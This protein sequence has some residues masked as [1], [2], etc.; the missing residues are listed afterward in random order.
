ME[1]NKASIRITFD[2]FGTKLTYLDIDSTGKVIDCH[3]HHRQ[4]WIGR[5]FN[6]DTVKQGLY[7]EYYLTDS[8]SEPINYRVKKII[9]L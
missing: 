7:P 5:K 1:K 3:P 4:V 8:Y 9:E 2:D 6:L